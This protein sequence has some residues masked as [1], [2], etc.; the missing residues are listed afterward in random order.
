MGKASFITEGNF[1]R[2]S[3]DIFQ[4]STFPTSGEMVVSVLELRMWFDLDGLL[5]QSIP[6]DQSR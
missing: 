5:L 3:A 2:D 4:P 1:W 6:Q